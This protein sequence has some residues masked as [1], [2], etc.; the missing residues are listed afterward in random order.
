MRQLMIYKRV[1]DPVTPGRVLFFAISLLA[2]LV[3]VAGTYLLIQNQ[4]K[5]TTQVTGIVES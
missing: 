4:G 5:K 2:G 3:S 1:H